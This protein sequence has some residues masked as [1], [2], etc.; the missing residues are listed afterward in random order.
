[1]TA[2]G[3][4]DGGGEGEIGEER[5]NSSYKLNKSWDVMY[6]KVTIVNN[7]VLS[8]GKFLREWILKVLI[9]RTK[10]AVNNVW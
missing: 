1:M 7:I 5:C 4:G 2:R 10:N 6:S 8:T 3:D 9:P